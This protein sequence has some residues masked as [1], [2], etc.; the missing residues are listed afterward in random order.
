MNPIIFTTTRIVQQHD[1]DELHHVNNVVY[2]SFLQDL[3]I[4]HW[5]STAP[6]HIIDSIRWIV[7]K[8]EIEY[9]NPARLGDILT[10][11]TWIEDFKGVQSN[12]AYEIYKDSTLIVKAKTLWI[13]IDPLSQKPKRLH[14]PDIT[15]LFFC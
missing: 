7:K 15:P 10:L 3:A 11:K 5:Q 4:N 13:S 14:L 1:L 2:L 8:H 9:F 6:F 12:R